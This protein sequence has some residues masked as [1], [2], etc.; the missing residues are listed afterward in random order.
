MQLSIPVIKIHVPNHSDLKEKLLKEIE[1]DTNGISMFQDRENNKVVIFK[2]DWNVA[3]DLENR[4]WIK[5]LSYELLPL[6][7]QSFKNYDEIRLFEIWYQQYVNNDEHSWHTH[8]HNLT[9]IYYVELPEDCP[10]TKIYNFDFSETIDL[11]SE[12]GYVCIIPS[13]IVHKSPQNESNSRKTI[14]SF[15][16]SLFYEK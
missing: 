9:G 3:A 6:I 15:N 12:E 14:V 11:P 16:F 4:Q 2:S 8:G 13:F 10:K 7:S 1:N 5:D